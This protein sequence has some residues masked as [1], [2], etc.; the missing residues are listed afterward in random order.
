MSDSQLV[1]RLL[2]V[3]CCTSFGGAVRGAAATLSIGGWGGISLGMAPFGFVFGAIIGFLASCFTVPLLWRK[4]LPIA[5]PIVFT[6]ALV[7][8]FLAG[9]RLRNEFW[10][11]PISV[12]T[13]L[14]ACA[15]V[16][17]FMPD[18]YPARKPGWEHRCRHCGYDLRGL[19]SKICPECGSDR[20]TPPA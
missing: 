19:P 10:S 16:W 4:N 2:G 11:V 5:M 18:L 9:W 3:A 6:P 13:L 7:A 8:A 12:G 20:G 15:I 14:I 1:S 17:Y